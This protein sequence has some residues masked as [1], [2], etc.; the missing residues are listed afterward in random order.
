MRRTWEYLEA[1]Q[2]AELQAAALEA[3]N[4]WAEEQSVRRAN[5]ERY[6]IESVRE[7][8]AVAVA[9]RPRTLRDEMNELAAAI[10]ARRDEVR[11]VAGWGR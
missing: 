10:E 2:A 8:A 9:D 6:L 3:S 11:A 5:N 4:A 7:R 1:M